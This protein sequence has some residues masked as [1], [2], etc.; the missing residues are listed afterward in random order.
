LHRKIIRLPARSEMFRKTFLESSD[1]HCFCSDVCLRVLRESVKICA[2]GK[3]EC[4]HDLALVCPEYSFRKAVK[5]ISIG[6]KYGHT[7]F[8]IIVNPGF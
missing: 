1:K 8:E 7:S 3:K 6:H 4:A 2:H 5:S